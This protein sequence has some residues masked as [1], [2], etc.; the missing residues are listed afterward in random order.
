MPRIQGTYSSQSV[1]SSPEVK[2][3]FK[4]FKARYCIS[5][6]DNLLQKIVKKIAR[7]VHS[8]LNIGT[9]KACSNA[10]IDSTNLPHHKTRAAAKAWLTGY[11]GAHSYQTP[12][13]ERDWVAHSG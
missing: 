2:T 10:V 8:Q 12:R 6:S 5:E 13:I 4:G 11:I 3:M 1:G 7:F 9:W